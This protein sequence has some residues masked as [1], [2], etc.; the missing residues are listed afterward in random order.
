MEAV[1]VNKVGGIYQQERIRGISWLTG[2]MW[3]WNQ[4]AGIIRAMEKPG[5]QLLSFLPV[6]KPHTHI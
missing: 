5:N 6:N 1:L 3:N 2:V 4:E